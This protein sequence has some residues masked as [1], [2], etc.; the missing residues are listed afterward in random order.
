M[1]IHKRTHIY[2]IMYTDIYIYIYT[3]VY[4]RTQIFPVDRLFKAQ[5]KLCVYACVY[6]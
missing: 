4:M 2:I 6:T 5:V 1:Y 3:C